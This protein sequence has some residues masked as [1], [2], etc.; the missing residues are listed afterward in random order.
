MMAL[1]ML[2]DGEFCYFGALYF[3]S[4]YELALLFFYME[5]YETSQ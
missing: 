2:D 1:E 4:S 5:I 3:G